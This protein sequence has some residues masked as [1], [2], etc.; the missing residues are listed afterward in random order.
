MAT[1]G[2]PNYNQL[3]VVS[4]PPGGPYGKIA[5]CTRRN[6]EKKISSNLRINTANI[7][8]QIVHCTVYHNGIEYFN[9]SSL[10]SGLTLLLRE[11]AKI[12]FFLGFQVFSFWHKVG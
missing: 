8:V 10:G 12:I 7:N 11:Q 6:I 1:R 9:S 2:T 3:I 4:A 5:R